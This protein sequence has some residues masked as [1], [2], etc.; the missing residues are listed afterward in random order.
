MVPV[1]DGHIDSL[2]EMYLQS[3][4]TRSLLEKSNKGHFDLPRAREGNFAGGMFAIFVPYTRKK[5]D[6]RTTFPKAE[7]ERLKPIEQK[8]A[9]KIA[10]K[11]I[12]CLYRLSKISDGKLQVVR[13]VNDVVQNMKSGIISAVIHF[14]GAEPIK[15]DLSNIEEFH[16]SGLR[17]VGIVWSR[18]N[19]FGYGVNFKFPGTPDT[20]PGLTDAGKELVKACN[21]LGIIVDLS[22]MNEKGFWDVE[23]I[24]EAPLVAT[25]SCIHAISPISRN[26]TDR[27]L[28]AIKAS[29]GI[30]GIN[31]CTGFLR[32][33][34]KLTPDTPISEIVRH[35]SYAANRMGIDHIFHDGRLRRTLVFLRGTI[36]GSSRST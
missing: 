15:Y 21:Q 32:S 23:R 30:V 12:E 4:S 11:G 9:E 25:H 22:H 27:Q 17:S 1:F 35:I 29:N 7:D 18:P 36:L 14:E 13:T 28:D 16:Q 2:Q 5:D 33:D 8:Y 6:N 31:F 24:S 34:S 26:L 20:G 10:E 19:V 3:D